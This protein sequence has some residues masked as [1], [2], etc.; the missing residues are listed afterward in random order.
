[1]LDPN[2]LAEIEHAERAL[3]EGSILGKPFRGEWG[4]D[5]WVKWSAITEALRRL[6]IEPGSSVLDIGCGTGWTTAFLAEA[7]YQPTGIDIAPAMLEVAREH[8]RRWQI[9][10]EFR[11]AD[12]DDFS[13]D[14]TFDAALV[15][16][17][18]HHSNHPE[19]VVANV[20]QHLRT[21]G[22]AL[23]GEP[24]WLHHISPR[25]R[26][27]H[28][29]TGCSEHGIP[30]SRLKSYCKQAGLSDFRRFFEA[31]RPYE[32]RIGEFL[33]QWI[34]LMAANVWVAPQASIWLAARK[35]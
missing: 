22:W 30:V 23:F 6:Q 34:R 18:L 5:Y 35:G 11:E 19:R 15:F 13:L 26:R 32:R 16:D 33:W 3:E 1:V 4:N 28:G 21:G 24:S 31:T 9:D 14:R 27:V 7:G 12:M 25:A 29:E 10:A 2:K 8:A 20:A 17:A